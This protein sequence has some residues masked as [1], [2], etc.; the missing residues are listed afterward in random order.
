MTDRRAITIDEAKRK[1]TQIRL[2]TDFERVTS[3]DYVCDH[4]WMGNQEWICFSWFDRKKIICG[5]NDRVRQS[6]T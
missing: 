3:H 2:A 6:G 1:S 5:E 4:G